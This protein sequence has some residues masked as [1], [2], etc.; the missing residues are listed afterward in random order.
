MKKENNDDMHILSQPLTTEDGFLNESCIK[1]LNSVIT[2][3]PKTYERLSKDPEWN[4]KRWIFLHDITGAFAKY[5]IVQSSYICPEGLEKVVNYLGECLKNEIK[6]TAHNMAELSLCDI[7]KLLYDILY[8][9]GVTIFDKW[10]QPK[11][12]WRE[13]DFDSFS[14]AEENDPDYGFIDLDALLHNVCLDIRME[15]R[16]FDK[17]NEEFEKKYNKE[18]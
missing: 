9:Q 16:S 10:N 1:E 18:K 5:A 11:K 14:Q 3:M 15:R 7:N 4:A 2:N 17:F 8:E 12:E 6:W 13:T